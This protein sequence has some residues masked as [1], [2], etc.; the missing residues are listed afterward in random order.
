VS[1]W[2]TKLSFEYRRRAADVGKSALQADEDVEVMR[3][4]HQALSWIQ[5]AENEETLTEA[6]QID[7]ISLS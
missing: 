7:R 4:L 2:C 5:L 3:L 1:K 6:E